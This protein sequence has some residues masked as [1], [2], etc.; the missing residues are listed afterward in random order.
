M[1][2]SAAAT[3]WERCAHSWRAWLTC[4]RGDDVLGSDA[5]SARTAA[6]REPCRFLGRSRR[7]FVSTS[8]EALA[9][10]SSCLVVVQGRPR[11]PRASADV[12]RSSRSRIDGG[13]DF[14]SCGWVCEL[15]TN[16]YLTIEQSPLFILLFILLFIILFI[17]QIW[18]I[19]ALAWLVAEL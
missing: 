5:F 13:R 3:T 18:N 11:F 4:S 16:K 17:N 1:A 9:P 15:I 2:T 14:E 19:V 12:S 10:N 8:Y 7:C 6:M